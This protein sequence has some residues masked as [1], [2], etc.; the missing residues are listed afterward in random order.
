MFILTGKPS[1]AFLPPHTFFWDWVHSTQMW[2]LTDGGIFQFVRLPC[3]HLTLH[4]LKQLLELS[5]TGG[6]VRSSSSHLRKLFLQSSHLQTCPAGSFGSKQGKDCAVTM[7]WVVSCI[8][9]QFMTN[10]GSRCAALRISLNPALGVTR[11]APLCQV[12]ARVLASTYL[13]Y[14]SW[15]S[16][17]LF[18]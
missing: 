13:C 9:L 3:V 11:V 8:Q 5:S 12:S 18:S 15:M 4:K 2:V 7:C 1:F 6:I 17:W 16:A 14:A 10:R